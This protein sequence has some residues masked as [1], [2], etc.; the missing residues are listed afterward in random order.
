MAKGKIIKIEKKTYNEKNY[1]VIYIAGQ[2]RP[3]GYWLAPGKYVEGQEVEY[4][5]T[6]DDKG[7]WKITFPDEKRGRKSE[8]KSPE[9]LRQSMVTMCLAYAKDVAIKAME[10]EV[11]PAD[12]IKINEFTTKLADNYLFWCQKKLNE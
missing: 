7:K 11:L 4:A 9:E 8:G 3:D 10:K 12:I 2:Q 5:E 6:K 1:D